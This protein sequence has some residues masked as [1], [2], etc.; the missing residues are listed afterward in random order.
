M[1]ELVLQR[2][3]MKRLTASTLTEVLVAM[4]I[5]MIISA[6]AIGIQVKITTGGKSLSQIRARQ[7][8]EALLK[9]D[10]EKNEWNDGEEIMIDSIV[11]RTSIKPYQDSHTLLLVHITAYRGSVLMGELKQVV[12]QR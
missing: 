12:S 8:M 5:I 10:F 2:M 9:T 4:V 3:V 6:I 11:Y 1:A 7:E